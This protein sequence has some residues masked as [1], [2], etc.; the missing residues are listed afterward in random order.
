MFS[1]GLFVNGLFANGLF[2]RGGTAPPPP[3]PPPVPVSSSRARGRLAQ[4][5][6]W[7]APPFTEGAT[8]LYTIG[9]TSE[10]THWEGID[11]D[12]GCRFSMSAQDDTLAQMTERDV[13]VYWFDPV[14]NG[15]DQPPQMGEWDCFRFTELDRYQGPRE[16]RILVTGRGMVMDLAQARNI[17]LNL[18]G[19]RAYEFTDTKTREAWIT[20]YVIPALIESGITWVELGVVD[21]A[22]HVTLAPAYWNP[23]RTMNELAGTEYEWQLRNNGD[24]VFYLDVVSAINGAESLRQLR[25]GKSLPRLRSKSNA[26][27]MMTRALASGA[28]GH[29]AFAKTIQGMRWKVAAVA[30]GPGTIEVRALDGSAV[31]AVRWDDQYTTASGLLYNWKVVQVRTGRTFEITDSVAL[32]PT[33]TLSGGVGNL[34]VGDE[35]EFREGVET[36]ATFRVEERATGNVSGANANPY[37]RR[38]NSISTNDLTLATLQSGDPVPTNDYHIDDLVEVSR[39]AVQLTVTGVADNG[40]GTTRI[41]HNAAAG[42]AVGQWGFLSSASAE[43]WG[44]APIFT[45]LTIV[46]STHIDVAYKHLGYTG[47]PYTA[48]GSYNKAR[49][50]TIQAIAPR[51]T[52][53]VAST[54]V[55]TVDSATGIVANDVI[56][57]YR[58]PAADLPAV[59]PAGSSIAQ[60]GIVDKEVPIAEG[61]GEHNLLYLLNPWFDQWA[62]TLPDGYTGSGITKSTTQL[63]GPATIHNALMVVGGSL[64]TPEFRILPSGGTLYLHVRYWFKTPIAAVWTGNGEYISCTVL[65]G[66]GSS[67]AFANR[68]FY[69]PD[70]TTDPSPGS[71]EQVEADT[72]VTV[73][74]TVQITHLS[75][76]HPLYK[77]LVARIARQG[78]NGSTARLAGFAVWQDAGAVPPEDSYTGRELD[79]LALHE[80]VHVELTKADAPDITYEAGIH[81]WSRLDVGDY[82]QEIRKGVPI[83]LD[84]TS[85]LSGATPTLRAVRVVY[86]HDRLSE[87]TV[88]LGE[89]PD[90]LTRDLAEAL[91]G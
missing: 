55:V 72:L 4:V 20:T 6:G 66:G 19:Y 62:S 51:V 36:P 76:G 67:T 75:A 64:T 28:K 65:A 59:I 9:A 18:G 46:D 39:F 60:Y 8:R 68:A 3:P 79:A 16:A 49:L 40:D 23:L 89:L 83:Q 91:D 58:L 38:V 1:L 81:D 37:P 26:L 69:P 90:S 13:L 10:R 21:D 71:S 57:F 54:D 84:S 56:E 77:G 22:T 50:Y 34:I 80:A 47:A 5:E 15:P 14:Q 29:S 32:P 85:V 24:G 53:E 82:D 12:E 45:I 63:I 27:P 48:I 25:E 73:T 7:N 78:L 35:I 86:N 44:A 42:I 52:D 43:P 70:A 31:P 11:N 17:S 88:T 87:T 2:L 30:S 41:T 74:L 33:L 61:R